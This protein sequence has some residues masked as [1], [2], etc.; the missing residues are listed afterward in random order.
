[1]ASAAL[2][3][4]HQVFGL[5]RPN[6]PHNFKS[7]GRLKLAEGTL[8]NA[9]WDEI[10]RFRPD[11]CVHAA[12]ISTPG[13]YLEAPENLELVHQSKA[14]LDRALEAG[15]AFSLV[16]GTCIEY[17]ASGEKL[18]ERSSPVA[19]VSLYARS[20]NQLREFLE[21][22]L[23][24][25]GLNLSWGRVFYPYGVGEHPQRL[26]SSV[27]AKLSTGKEVLLKTPG[28]IKDYIYITDLA[29]AILTVIEKRTAGVINLGTG[30]G[31]SILEMTQAIA[32][33]LGRREL[34]R[35]AAEPAVDAYPFVVADA[36]RLKSLGWEPKIGL[37]QGIAALIEHLEAGARK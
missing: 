25:K 11:V 29:A 6:R 17:G 21:A 8:E 30:Q 12:W 37:E 19:P 3:R 7:E 22:E 28:S 35:V 16:L 1:M 26:C 10:R 15:V 18:N 20:K 4:G 27:I 24:P 32:S 9:P 5:V 14:F 36:S 13:I 23:M 31:T 2:V 33:M 34:V